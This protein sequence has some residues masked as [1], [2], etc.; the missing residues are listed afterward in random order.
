MEGRFDAIQHKGWFGVATLV[1][2]S[3]KSLDKF[4][5]LGKYFLVDTVSSFAIGQGEPEL[6]M[7][8]IGRHVSH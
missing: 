5:F 8:A 3:L 7:L 1:L 6:R 4:G 2:S